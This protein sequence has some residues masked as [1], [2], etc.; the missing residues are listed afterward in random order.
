M[1]KTIF[2]V[3]VS[4]S[5]LMNVSC[6]TSNNQSKV[7]SIDFS[8]KNVLDSLIK[9]T[10]SSNDTIFLGF[11][12]G[13]SKTDYR[14][15]IYKLRNEGLSLTYSQSNMIKTFV[16]T[17]ELGS[18][19]TFSTPISANVSDKTVNGQGQ[20]FLEPQYNNQDK[21]VRLNVISVEKWSSYMSKEPNWFESRIEENSIPFKN[22][23]FKKALVDNDIISKHSFIRQKGNVL[24]FKNSNTYSYVPINSILTE[25]L[26]NAIEKELIEE[27][28][29]TITF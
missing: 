1:R 16:G 3:L 9:T 20:Y 12:M 26:L 19:Y 22:E 24:I 10:P 17:F 4:I 21:L 29:Q 2:L 5:L 8:D 23:S 14:N 7:E 18:G 6:E 27:K 28:N 13:M 25:L 15:H 11:I